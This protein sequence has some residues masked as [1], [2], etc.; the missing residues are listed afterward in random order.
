MT[1]TLIVQLIPPIN[2]IDDD[3]HTS[4][5]CAV[6]WLQ[7]SDAATPGTLN[8]ESGELSRLLQQPPVD[9]RWI[10]LI[11]G[12]DVLTTT[13]NLPKKR[14]R[15][16]I[17][18]LPFM[19]EDSIASDVTLEHMAVGP[20]NAQ[21]ETLVAITRKQHL[22]DL[23]QAFTDAGI[24][25]Y[26]M[27]PDYAMLPENTD[28]W[29]ILLSA[30]RAM[31]RCPDSTGFS[32]SVSRLALLLNIAKERES[33]AAARSVNWIRTAGTTAPI[34]VLP[35]DWKISEQLVASPLQHFA[36]EATD[37][38]LN[39]LQDEFKVIQQDAWNW[40]PWATAAVLALVAICIGLLDT[41]LDTAR[42][43]RE[44]DQLQ[45]SMIELAREALPG[46]KQI[47]D[48]QTQLLIAWRQLKNGGS[49]GAGFLPLLNRVSATINEQPITVNGINFKDG[50][51]TVALQ[52]TSLQQL[53]NLRQQIEQQGL[54]AELLNA[55]TDTDSAHS[56]LVIKTMAPQAPRSAG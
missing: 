21:G 28:T 8:P 41:G 37:A 19:L 23:L 50:T 22:R 18:A 40:R 31:V 34:P 53:D 52:G 11:P 14:R 27:L 16:A 3:V 29:Q 10:V 48:P 49:V 4:I 45:T 24:T 39:L 25:P 36:A 7:V 51:L 35:E 55:G 42:F 33:G 20:D 9:C 32:T 6:Q 44:N 5:D 12:E 26:K 56:D 47:R 30:D 13:V 17:N 46:T 1:D 43:N 38:S 15:Q 2:G 54:N